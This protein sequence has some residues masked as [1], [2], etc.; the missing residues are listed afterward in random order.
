MNINTRKLDFVKFNGTEMDFVKFNGVT[1]YEA[2][3][4]LIASGVPPITLQKCKGVDLVDYKI[5]GNSVQEYK[6]LFDVQFT[7]GSLNMTIGET[8]EQQMMSTT[9]NR[10][11]VTNPITIQPN[12][13]YTIK[14]SHT[15]TLAFRLY[16]ENGLCTVATSVSMASGS[17]TFNSENNR[18]MAFSVV[19]T[20]E[21]NVEYE[22]FQVQPTP[23]A[24]IEIK[25]VGEKTGNLFN[26]RMV[27]GY[28]TNGINFQSNSNGSYTANGTLTSVLASLSIT[29]GVELDK[30]EIGETYYASCGNE[31]NSSPRRYYMF[32]I[33]N[34]SV[35]GG[36]RYFSASPTSKTFTLSENEY[37]SSVEC[38]IY[39]TTGELFT[40]ENLILKP[41]I[42][43][44]SEY[45]GYEPYGYKIPIKVR[46]KNYCTNHWEIGYVRQGDG[47]I[48][49]TAGYIR[50]DYMELPYGKT[51]KVSALTDYGTH[52]GVH[53]YDKDLNYI[54]FKSTSNGANFTPLENTAYVRLRLASTDINQ[55]IQI[56]DSTVTTAY[57]DYKEPIMYGKNMLNPI[58]SGD[59]WGGSGS[60]V[61]ITTSVGSHSQIVKVKPN[62][63]YV[64]SCDNLDTMND[65]TLRV[66]ETA[67]YPVLG[68]ITGK[69][70]NIGNQGS[71]FELNF[72]TSEDTNYLLLSSGGTNYTDFTSCK[73][74]VEEGTVKT[75]YESYEDSTTL[76]IYLKEPLR[77]EGSYADYIDFETKK[78]YRQIKETVLDGTG[79]YINAD[80]SLTNTYR[81]SKT[82]S[83]ARGTNPVICDKLK[84]ITSGTSSNDTENIQ[85]SGTSVYIRIKR[86]RLN[87]EDVAGV[88]EYLALNP[89]TFYYI[90][91]ASSIK[92]EEMELPDIQ[93]HKGTNII[94]VDTK[95]KP[96]N[97][98][99]T[100]LGKK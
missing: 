13:S 42:C 91:N 83:D 16:D 23:D 32:L 87:S 36:V 30:I 82:F 45:V 3:K 10:I 58:F 54:G 7:I 73:I 4:K 56:A 12:T 24:P 57:E 69:R 65:K 98:E 75:P 67:E 80:N 95:I 31:Y 35:T 59:L 27:G 85:F 89:I 25:S 99:V 90:L 38:R 50:T 49:A 61:A 77:K 92:E 41:I 17:Y 6:N 14:S 70:R 18:S 62:T 51:Y 20:T 39:S 44:A 11:T 34:N 5:Y 37:I 2:W 81:V 76:K 79:T 100:Y 97:M 1:I 64:I 53:C 60:G 21:I 19:D 8:F 63:N 68:G 96:S 86:N 29:P 46:G 72:T 52:I 84:P 28:K 66:W 74:Q 9:T 40:V 78:V 33:I 55:Q 47:K 22:M 88:K 94:E 26:Y 48:E 71:A 93:L 43:K 15:K